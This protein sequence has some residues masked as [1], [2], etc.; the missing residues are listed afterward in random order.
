MEESFEFIGKLEDFTDAPL[1]RFHVMVPID[2]AT[3]LKAGKNNR[4]L[5]NLNNS[6]IIHS[7][8]M[9]NGK[10][11][12]FIM[13]N[14]EIRAELNLE[15]GDDIHVSICPDNSKYGME[16]PEELAEVLSAD[17]IGSQLFH[18]LPKGKQRNLI[19]IVAKPKQSQTRINK[20]LTILDYLNLTDGKLDFK[21]LNIAFKTSQYK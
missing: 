21:E 9:P 18:A 12:D 7:P 1:W 15:L 16:M 3:K 6:K 19:H 13:L 17:K 10:G 8:L 2:I 14:K 5:V 11:R 20:A 4:T